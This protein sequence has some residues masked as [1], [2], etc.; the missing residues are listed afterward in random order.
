[1]ATTAVSSSTTSAASTP[2]PTAASIAATNKANA[3]KIMT[4]MGAGSGVD[5]TSLAQSLVNAEK[6]PKQNEINTKI[7]KNDARVSGYSAVMFMMTELNKSFTALK[8]RNNFNALSASN[9]NTSAFDVIAGETAATGHHDIEVTRLAKAQRTVSAGVASATAPLNGGKA[10]SLSIKVGDASAVARLVTTRQGVAGATESASVTFQDLAVG[11]QVTVGGLTYTATQATT[12][13]D[14]ADAFANAS[15][16]PAN[17]TF[18]GSLTGFTA[19]SAANAG[20]LVFNSALASTNVTDLTVSSTAAI[21]PV[22][23]TS[24]GVAAVTERTTVT[25]KDMLPGESITVGGLKYTATITTTAAQVATAFSGLQADATTPSNPLTGT[26]T[27]TLTGFN[28]GVSDGTGALAFTSSATNANVTDLPIFG[29]SADISL[30]DGKDTPQGIVDAINASKV[31][32]TA[33]LVNTGDG[34]ATPYQIILSGPVGLTGAFSINTS[35][36]AGTGTPGLTFPAGPANQ[37]ATD[38]LVKVDGINYTRSSNTLVDV[39]PGLTLN[40]RA[41]TSSAASV[42]LTRDN[43]ILK[44]KFTALVTAYNDADNILAE[45]S[46]PKST[47]DTYGATLVGD[48]TVRSLR[49][50]LRSMISGLSSTPGDNVKSMAQMGVNV[51]QKGVMSLDATK[52]D[53]AL[54]DYYSDVVK[55]FTG[56]Y[57]NL[58]TYSTLSAGFAGDAVKKITNIIGNKGAL[59][60]NTTTANTQNTKY[61]ADLEKLNTRMDS[62]LARYTK[63][64]SAMDSLVGQVNSQKTSLKSTF[65]GMMA[66]YTKA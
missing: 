59:T 18:S 8:D 58:G 45:V 62:L 61:K 22:V 4:S 44:D 28:G 15:T 37:T 43:T 21:A 60:T 38:A 47:L 23:S 40:L 24:Q 41:T 63:Q 14:L 48:S 42:D 52:L 19:A 55:S 65:D 26:F 29:S 39:V 3:Q 50:Q 13:A 25:F 53:A 46:N 6:L 27:G 9:S 7:T 11:E 36:G 5:V 56:G 16:T 17:G 66:S 33:Q 34:S 20:T 64:F 10:M 49:Q 32:V 57:N 1:M 12:A 35:Y 30:V 54:T 51:D 31:G 2:A